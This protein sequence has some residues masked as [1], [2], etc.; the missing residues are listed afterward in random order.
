MAKEIRT[1]IVIKASKEQVWEKLMDLE[2]Y[3]E[4]NPFITEIEGE[5]KLGAQL[6]VKI[7]PPKSKGMTFKPTIT[8][9]DE[10]QEF[11]WLGHLFFSGIFDGAH[12][13]TLKENADGSTTFEQSERFTGLLSRMINLEKTEEGFEKMNNELKKLVESES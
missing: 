8:K 10:N 6:K 12:K 2:N 1:Q 5:L 7:V 3:Q 9:I 11:S 4:W 13:F